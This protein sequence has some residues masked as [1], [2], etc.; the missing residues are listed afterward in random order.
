[1]HAPISSSRPYLIRAIYQWIVDN[2]LTPYLLV[3]ARFPD[4]NVPSHYIQDG[5]IVL[6]LAP[7]AVHGL[8]LGNEE[9]SFSARFGGRPITVDV[10]VDRVMAIYARENGQGLMLGETEKTMGTHTTHQDA[11]TD[12]PETTDA[13]VTP[14]ER[15][16]PK[17]RVVK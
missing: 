4:V 16:I 1:M 6:N 15:K 2:D 3:D 17:L 7:M 10:P 8:T 5:R 14:P 12:E 9:I 13:E 11:F